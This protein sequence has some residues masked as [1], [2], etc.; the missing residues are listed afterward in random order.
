MKTKVMVSILAV[1]MLAAMAFS[2]LA[3]CDTGNTP[4]ETT[5]GS[6][7][8]SGTAQAQDI[9]QGNTVFRFEVI[10]DEGNVSVWNV[11]TDEQTV[12]DALV[13]VGLIDGDE[14]AFG[15]MVTEVNGL[16]SDFEAN[17]SW[18]KLLIDGAEAMEGV[19]SIEIETGKVYAFV[20]T[21]GF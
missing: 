14:S 2:M 6:A 12:G 20:Y 10:D 9:G 16:A 1:I 19:S 15:L 17:E 5:G 7:E 13:A 8:T 11:S 21:I 18:W 4:G 3:A